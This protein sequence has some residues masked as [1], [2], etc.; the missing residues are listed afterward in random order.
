MLSICNLPFL[1][2]FSNRAFGLMFPR[3]LIV[4]NIFDPFCFH[5]YAASKEMADI[6]TEYYRCF[7]SRDIIVAFGE[8]LLYF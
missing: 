2:T 1:S 7:V 6:N 4:R 3:I 5:S 8:G